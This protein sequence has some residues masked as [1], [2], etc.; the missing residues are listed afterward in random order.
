MITFLPKL[1]DYVEDAA[2]CEC[3]D[4]G[5]QMEAWECD[6]IEDFHKRLRAGDTM[7][8]GECYK[9][10]GLAFLMDDSDYED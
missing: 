1:P 6:T 3:Q 9:C 5:Q 7:P 8:A 4:C 2:L 10:G